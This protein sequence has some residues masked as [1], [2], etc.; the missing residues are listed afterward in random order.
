MKASG[1]GPESFRGEEALRFFTEP[2]NIWSISTRTYLQVSFRTFAGIPR[3]SLR[4]TPRVDQ[5][6]RRGRRSSDSAWRQTRLVSESRD[7]SLPARAATT[8]SGNI[9]LAISCENCR[10]NRS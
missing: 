9:S 2:K 4:E 1:V 6:D 3:L 8:R 7:K 5:E 10:L